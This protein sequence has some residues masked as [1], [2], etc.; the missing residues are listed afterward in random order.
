VEGVSLESVQP[1][2]V[3]PGS[4]LLVSGGPFAEGSWSDVRLRIE[5]TF[6][7]SGQRAVDWSLPA[8]VVDAQTLAVDLPPSRVRALAEGA[9]GVLRG[10]AT[11]RATARGTGATH[12]SDPMQIELDVAASLTPEVGSVQTEGPLTVNAELAVR[13]RGL[14][15]GGGEGRTHAVL[16]GCFRRRGDDE[17]VSTEPVRV[18]VQV[19]AGRSQ[20]HFRF[21]PQIAGI[22]P[23]RFE[24]TLVLRNEHAGG[25]VAEGRSHDVQYR[26]LAPHVTRLSPRVVSLGQRLQVRGGGFVGGPDGATW[27]RL[28]GML[29]PVRQNRR[30]QAVDVSVVVQPRAGSKAIYVVNEDDALGQQLELRGGG[31]TTFVGEAVPTVAWQDERVVGPATEVSFEVGRLRQVVHLDFGRG[32]MRS[33][34]HFGLRAADSA[35][36]A[37]LLEV[38]RR[39]Y[40]GLAVDFRTEAPENYALHTTLEISGQDPNGLGLLGYDNTPGKDTGNQR[41]DE[42]IGGVNAKTQ[43]D[44]SPGYGGIFVQSLFGFSTH[45]NGLVSE[46]RPDADATFDAIFDPFRPDVGGEPVRAA[47]VAGGI[48]PRQDGEGCP[49]SSRREQLRCAVFVLGSLIGTTASHELGH[50]LGLSDPYGERVHPEGDAPNRLMD[51]GHHRPF[52]ERAELYGLGP[53][54]F[55]KRAYEYLRAILPSEGPPADAVPRPQCN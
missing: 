38:L 24:G 10:A 13:G 25:G 46:P 39:D 51:A 47:D 5:G 9:R 55:C 43:Q 8:R 12:T 52:L 33:L 42:Q 31:G 16:S 40:A 41:L 35:V 48:R 26:L 34:A 28:Q 32:Y 4:K 36:R 22:E 18:P 15:R 20:G 21:S 29:V 49:A 53:A 11:V 7:A 37:R 3:V 54:R 50:A 27:L 2:T 19:E 23:A 14:L 1:Q 30:A 6:E 44:G 17:C 45:P